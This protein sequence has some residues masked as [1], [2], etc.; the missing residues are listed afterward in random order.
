MLTGIQAS[1]SFQ[2]VITLHACIVFFVAIWPFMSLSKKLFFFVNFQDNCLLIPDRPLVWWWKGRI[3]QL[4]LVANW[5]LHVWSVSSNFHSMLNT[6]YTM[7]IRSILRPHRT[8]FRQAKKCTH[9]KDRVRPGDGTNLSLAKKDEI[10]I[11]GNKL[12]PSCNQHPTVLAVSSS[13][14]SSS[15]MMRGHGRVRYCLSL[16]ALKLCWS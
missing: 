3:L 12:L 16:A 2:T 4:D 8:N 5:Q 10:N 1:K 6:C 7:H 9:G 11:T 13:S 15:V 14:S